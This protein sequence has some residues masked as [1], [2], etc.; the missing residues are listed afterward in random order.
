MS[1]RTAPASPAAGGYARRAGGPDRGKQAPKRSGAPAW[2]HLN[3][4]P[5]ARKDPQQKEV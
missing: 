3:P 2:I 4:G 1:R 5:T